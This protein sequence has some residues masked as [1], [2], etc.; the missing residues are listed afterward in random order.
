MFPT[1]TGKSSTKQFY[2]DELNS[3]GAKADVALDFFLDPDFNMSAST[4]DPKFEIMIWF[5][6]IGATIPIGYVNGSIGNTILDGK[7]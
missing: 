2:L 3:I 1:E 4:T 7:N 6:A 5:S